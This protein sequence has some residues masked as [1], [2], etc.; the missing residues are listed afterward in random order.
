MAGARLCRRH[1]PQAGAASTKSW[2]QTTATIGMFMAAA[3]HHQGVGGWAPPTR[4]KQFRRWAGRIP[5]LL[6]RG[7]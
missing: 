3:S 1:A 5:F 4:A 6:F 2:I 7:I